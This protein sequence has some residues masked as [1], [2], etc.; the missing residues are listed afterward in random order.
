MTTTACED[1][2]AIEYCE[3]ACDHEEELCE[4]RVKVSDE[5]EYYDVTRRRRPLRGS[6]H[7]EDEGRV[8]CLGGS[9]PGGR[10][11]VPVSPFQ[12]MLQKSA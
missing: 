8:E 3:T 5:V 4:H 10:N 2:R 1:G 12:F 11:S 7:D 6:A 9:Q